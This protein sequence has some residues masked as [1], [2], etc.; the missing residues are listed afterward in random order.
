M[1]PIK[2]IQIGLSGDNQNVDIGMLHKSLF[3]GLTAKNYLGLYKRMKTEIEYNDFYL[4][5]SSGMCKAD[6]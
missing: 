5:E 1:N 6:D 2:D 3:E 4:I